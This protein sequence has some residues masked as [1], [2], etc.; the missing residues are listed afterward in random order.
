MTARVVAAVLVSAV[1][2]LPARGEEPKRPVA[3]ERYQTLTNNNIFV[4][5][6]R[7]ARSSSV[8]SGA[9]SP[10]R[11]GSS[12]ER[13]MVLTGIVRHDG[14]YIAF[15]EDTR[16]RATTRV[17]IG[18][19]LGAG[20]VTAMTLDALDYE[21]DG[22]PV[23]VEVGKNFEGGVVAALPPSG[24]AGGDTTSGAAGASAAGWDSL[25]E[26]M[27]QRRLREMGL[28]PTPT[29]TIESA[30]PNQENQP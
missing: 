26:R 16:T 17:R 18:E 28:A 24:S 6:R 7:P 15:V 22:A 9:A 5:D 1:A 4:K 3:W 11:E 30:A 20:R 29:T 8:P 13:A 2:L 25:L 27:R 10:R 21:K 12:T 14:E 23:R 19:A